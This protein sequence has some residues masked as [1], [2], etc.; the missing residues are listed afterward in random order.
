M[1]QNIKQTR[2]TTPCRAMVSIHR[3]GFKAPRSTCCGRRV[4]QAGASLVAIRQSL[5]I[6]L[7]GRHW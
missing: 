7:G 1:F 3:R 5:V 4:F 6:R 2:A